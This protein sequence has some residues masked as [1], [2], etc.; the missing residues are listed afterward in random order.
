MERDAFKAT[1]WSTKLYVHI[2]AT[3]QQ[4]STKFSAVVT[5][6]CQIKANLKISHNLHIGNYGNQIRQLSTLC[7]YGGKS[8]TKNLCSF[9]FIYI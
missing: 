8:R 3:T 5:Y 9:S 6:K 1:S 2:S 7:I 4:I